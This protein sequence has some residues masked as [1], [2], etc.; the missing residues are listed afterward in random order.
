MR[1]QALG[2]E[3]FNIHPGTTGGLCTPEVCMDSIADGVNRALAE[4]SGVCVVLENV[5]GQVVPR[6][7]MHRPMFDVL[8]VW[9]Q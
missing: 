6:R 4:T 2:I 3:R 8:R 7:T 5:A 1:T 9:K